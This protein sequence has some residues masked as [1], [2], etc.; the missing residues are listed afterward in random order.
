MVNGTAGFEAI[1]LNKQV[2]TFG[3][4]FFNV[5]ERVNYIKNIKDLKE[6]IY[7]NIGVVYEDD[8]RLHKFI[9]AFLN[10]THEG[11]TDFFQGRM[12]L[13]D[14]DYDTNITKIAANLS[15]FFKTHAPN[16]LN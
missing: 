16:N 7:N 5:C 15:L 14:I 3:N 8:F 12:S 13:Y 10:S 4:M 1:M 2:Y 9:L 11:V 6:I